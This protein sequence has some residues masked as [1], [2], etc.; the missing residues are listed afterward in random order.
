MI[1]KMKHKHFVK[2]FFKEY[3]G[4]FQLHSIFSFKNRVYYK[5]IL[6]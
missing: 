5:V 2:S 1:V 3:L 6:F 4:H